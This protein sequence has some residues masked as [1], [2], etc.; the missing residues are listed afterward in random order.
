MSDPRPCILVL[1]AGSSSLKFALYDVD[2]GDPALTGQMSDARWTEF[3]EMA[4][5]Q[6]VYPAELDP[7]SAYTLDFL[8]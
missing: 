3:Y 7:K 1:N 4:R 2:A 5:D 6:G 8:P